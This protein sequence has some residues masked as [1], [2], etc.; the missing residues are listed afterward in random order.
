MPV[1][2][3]DK[4]TDKYIFVICNILEAI[5]TVIDAQHYFFSCKKE[6]SISVR[7]GSIGLHF[8]CEIICLALRQEY[9]CSSNTNAFHQASVLFCGTLSIF[10]GFIFFF[11]LQHIS[12][13]CNALLF[14]LFQT[15]FIFTDCIC[16]SALFSSSSYI[17][18]PDGSMS[19]V[20]RQP[21]L[22]EPFGAVQS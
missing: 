14:F 11:I 22:T 6:G 8:G 1:L 5:N 13:Y 18:N 3:F 10:F 19:A 17:L 20:R 7:N 21:A 9:I 15:V 2:C 4:L 12:C 16:R